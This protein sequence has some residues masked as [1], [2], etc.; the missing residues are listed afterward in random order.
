M[1]GEGFIRCRERFSDAELFYS[2]ECPKKVN[3]FEKKIVLRSDQSVKLV[4]FVRQVLN[5]NFD[6]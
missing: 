6:T 2:T 1:D 5:L 4:S 3:K